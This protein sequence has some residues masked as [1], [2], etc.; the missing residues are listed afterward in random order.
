[1]L[2]QLQLLVFS[3][4]GFS[5][6]M[7][8]G[9]YPPELRSV[10]LDF[11]W[12]YRRLGARVAMGAAAAITALSVAVGTGL[13]AAAVRAGTGLR[14]VHGLDGV[15]ARTWST[16]GMVLWVALMLAGYLLVIYF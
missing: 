4:L 7:R 10:N 11:D 5:V 16:G 9:I 6:L 1:V 12:F 3:A 13:R 14:G 8:T 15:L 2:S